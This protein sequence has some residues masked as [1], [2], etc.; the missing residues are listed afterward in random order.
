M[1]ATGIYVVTEAKEKLTNME[2]T[3]VKIIYILIL[4]ELPHP[5]PT[6]QKNL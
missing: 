6:P 4:R 1:C 5:T 3:I 2:K